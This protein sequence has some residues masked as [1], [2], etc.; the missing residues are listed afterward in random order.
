MTALEGVG[1]GLRAHSGWAALVAVAGTLRSPEILLRRSI[2][3]A[4]P[5]VPGSKQPYHA[6]EG[7]KLPKAEKIIGR[8]AS[9]AR[10]LAGRAFDEVLAGLEKGKRP[11]I[12]C[13]LL[14]ASGRP[15]PGLEAILASHALIHTA[16]GEL[17][18]DALAAAAQ[19]RRL[20]VTRVREKEI[21]SRAAASLSIPEEEIAQ[22]LKAAGRLVGSPWTQ[23]QKLAALAAWVALAGSPLP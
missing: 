23:D 21:S 8:C 7:E 12:A 16:D 10:R 13:G 3:L 20:P 1:L 4:D 2:E 18:R 15:L 14:L 17:F 9:D 19:E 5:K 22:C 6:A 11:V